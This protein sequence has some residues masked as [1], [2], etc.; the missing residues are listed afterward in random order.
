MA[1]PLDNQV[2]RPRRRGLFFLIVGGAVLATIVAVALLMNI[3]ER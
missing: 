1:E 2:S 3:F